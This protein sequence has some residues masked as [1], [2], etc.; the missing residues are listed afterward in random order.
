MRA[1]LPVNSGQYFDA[2]VV[3]NT[4][5]KI[6][7]VDADLTDLWTAKSKSAMN[8]A[9]LM[10]LSLSQS[11]DNVPFLH[12]FV[13]AYRDIKLNI[14]PLPNMI[15]RLR[16]EMNHDLGSLTVIDI[17][18]TGSA[19]ANKLIRLVSSPLYASA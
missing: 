16:E 9:E 19:I 15:L 11:L 13:E 5:V 12:S 4:E 18:Q 17:I 6:L 8:F 7:V 1:H 2:A 14:P 10:D 3:V